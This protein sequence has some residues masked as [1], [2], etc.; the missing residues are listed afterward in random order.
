MRSSDYVEY[1]AQI[2]AGKSAGSGQG[3]HTGGGGNLFPPPVDEADRMNVLSKMVAHSQYC[4]SGDNTLKATEQAINRA[5][6]EEAGVG[7]GAGAEVTTENYIVVVSDANFARYGISPHR[8]GSVMTR[9]QHAASPP[10]VHFVFLASMDGEA[11]QIVKE[12][13]VGHGHVCLQT[14]DLPNILKDILSGAMQ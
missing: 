14:Q 2:Q 8:L 10:A 3:A 13:P 9:H 7:N 6:D 11:Q 5:M 12:L 1:L 4:M